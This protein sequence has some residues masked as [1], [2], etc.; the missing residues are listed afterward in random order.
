MLL[1]G[2]LLYGSFTVVDIIEG[3]IFSDQWL[4]QGAFGWLTLPPLTFPP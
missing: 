3:N 1:V 4:G 2:V